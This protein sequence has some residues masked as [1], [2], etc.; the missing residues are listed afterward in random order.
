MAARKNSKKRKEKMTD[1]TFAGVVHKLATDARFHID[2]EIQPSRL[3][4]SQ[5]YDG[6][7]FGDENVD[8]SAIV[9]TTIRDTVNSVLPSLMRV[10]AGS[11]QAVEFQPRTAAEV[12][13]AEEATD[14]INDLFWNKCSGF[15]EVL[16]PAFQDAL[17]RKTG[18]LYWWYTDRESTRDYIYKAK[19]DEEMDVFLE[20]PGNENM[21][22]V[23]KYP[24][25]ADLTPSDR[26]ADPQTDEA[27][28]IVEAAIQ[29]VLA[30]AAPEL[31]G[32]ALIPKPP[33]YDFRVRQKVVTP[34]PRV[35]A[36]PPEQYIISRSA[37]SVADAVCQGRQQIVTVSDLVAI[38]HNYDEIIENRGST[39][40]HGVSASNVEAQ[41]RNP[42][43]LWGR[44]NV[45]GDESL[46]DVLYSELYCRIDRDGDGIAELWRVETIGTDHHI[47]HAEIFEEE[48]APFALLCPFPVSGRPIG[49]SLADR[50]V[51]L[52]EINSRLWR[53]V[54]DSL[55]QSIYSRTVVQEGMVNIDDVLNTEPGAIIR[56][57]TVGAV[58]EFTHQFVGVQAMQVGQALD[59]M[60]MERTGITP[61]SYLDPEAL[62]STT[63]V[64]V[65]ASIGA[66]DQTN[67]IIA[68]RFAENG[69]KQMFA[70]LLRMVCRHVDQPLDIT[71]RDDSLTRVDPR[72][73]SP[74]LLT[75]VNVGL[76]KGKDSERYAAYGQILNAQREFVT[77]FGFGG[78][79]KAA[80]MR[81]TISKMAGLSGV[82]DI[83]EFIPAI[84]EDWTPPAPA[85]EA[86]P[87]LELARGQVEASMRKVEADELKIQLDHEL[88]MHELQ[89]NAALKREQMAQDRVLKLAE[90]E[91]RFGSD[92][93]QAE[94]G[95]QIEIEK[96]RIGTISE[97]VKKT[98]DLDHAATQAA[99]DRAQALETYG[100]DQHATTHQ[101]E[102]DAASQPPT[103]PGA[104]E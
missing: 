26:E 57:R 15:A 73:W 28:P 14:A 87:Q 95:H 39:P 88:K 84:P 34:C 53:G 1:E 98:A 60:K 46:S 92:L 51:D 103:Q 83:S 71:R 24:A 40:M 49:M 17:I 50:L 11:A 13:M 91:A 77:A 86:N 96:A 9:I 33:R 32:M 81:K 10:F 82:A 18:I 58:Q 27:N 67:E 104:P 97:H 79:I 66:A 52:Q 16:E 7:A 68:R 74:D 12:K 44:D 36:I 19:T 25:D 62:Q 5:Y 75:R 38:G 35:A 80:H 54:L 61:A 90:I 48:Q 70:G 45:S 23:E 37:T 69:L 31:A 22:I 85:Q 41:E 56:A 94:M 78:P 43:L 42:A 30:Q 8:E 72:T 2:T 99:L 89:I 59:Q 76:G 55:T 29:D 100:L 3:L 20:M 6:K 47:L 102:M 21:E 93:K 63:A 64:G 101:S 4:A 65:E